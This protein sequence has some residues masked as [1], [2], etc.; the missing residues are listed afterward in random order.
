MATAKII[1]LFIHNLLRWAIVISSVY[2]L[3]I[4]FKGWIKNQAWQDAHRKALMIFTMLLDTQLLLGLLLYFVFS[5]LTKAAF[6]DFSAAMGNQ[7]LRFFTVE[8]S[9]LM[10]LAIVI[11]HIASAVG[12]KDLPDLDKFKRTAILT[13]IAFFLLI[14]GIPWTIRPLIPGF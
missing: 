11:G 2:T 14:G 9:L 4:L 1:T 8:H 12:K 7:I 13:A 5:D 6:A 10:V 3:F